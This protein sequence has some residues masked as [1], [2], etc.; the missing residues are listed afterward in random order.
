M[1][2][3]SFQSGYYN[4]SE[5]PYNRTTNDRCMRASKQEQVVFNNETK[6]N[7]IVVCNN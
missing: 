3:Y 4:Q 5:A 7:G 2:V 6:N 1:S